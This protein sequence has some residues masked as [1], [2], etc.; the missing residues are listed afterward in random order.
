M[1]TDQGSK[2][3]QTRYTRQDKQFV[4]KADSGDWRTKLPAESVQ[5]IEAAW[6][7]IMKVLGYKLSKEATDLPA[8]TSTHR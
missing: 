5:A 4:R 1:E 6:G 8:T 2:W 7:E 3:V